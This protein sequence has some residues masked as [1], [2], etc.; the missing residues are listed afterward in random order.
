V[1]SFLTGGFL[2][3][4]GFLRW[5]IYSI[6][7]VSFAESGNPGPTESLRKLVTNE[8]LALPGDRSNLT[9]AAAQDVDVVIQWM[10]RRIFNVIPNMERLSWEQHVGKGFNIPLSEMCLTFLFVAGYL[11]IWFVLGHYLIKWREIATW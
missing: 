9:V 4:L 7:V 8:A 3:N 11:S 10:M 1:V 2:V 6:V 5:F